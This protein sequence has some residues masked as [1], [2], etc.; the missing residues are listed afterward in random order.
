MPQRHVIE[1]VENG[2]IHVIR[3]ADGDFFGIAPR[4]ARNEL[5]RD[6]HVA[7][8]EIHVHA[9]D[10]R[11]QRVGIRFDRLLREETTHVGRLD[12]RQHIKVDLSVFV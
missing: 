12:E 7:L 4:G 8:R 3:A 5:V 10:R 6:K 2:R 11:A 1:A 9:V